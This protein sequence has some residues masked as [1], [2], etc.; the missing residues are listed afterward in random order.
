VIKRIL[1]WLSGVAIGV[2]LLL[3]LASAA[4]TGDKAFGNEQLDQMLAQIALYP[5]PLLSQV[6]MAATYPDEFAAAVAWSKAH[7]DAKGDAAVKMVESE[8]WDPSVASLVAF[9]DALITLGDKP[10]YVRNLGDAFLAQPQ[11]VMDSVQRLRQNAQKAGNLQSNEQVKVSTQ[12]APP[13]AATSTTVVVQQAAPPPQVIV[14][15]PAQPSVV[16]VPAYNPAVVYGPWWYPSYPPYYYPPPPGYWW[17]RSIATGIA[18]GVG[19]GVSN[20][21]WG[22]FD[23]GRGDVNINVNRYNNINVNKR[24][25]VNARNTTWNHDPGHRGKAPYK[26]GD[27]T[28]QKLE[29]QHEVGNREQFRGKEAARDGG[30][31]AGRDASRDASREQAA[32]AMKDRSAPSAKAAPKASATG[33]GPDRDAARQK[34]QDADRDAA[35]QRA[36]QASKDNALKGVSDRQ[37]KQQADRGA[38]SQ[39]AAQRQKPEPARAP[40][41]VGGGA[42]ASAASAKPA[43]AKPAAARPAAANPGAGNAGAAKAGGAAA[44]AGAAKADG[45]GRGRK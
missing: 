9:P 14:I 42:K 21:L 7:P 24:I 44:K 18:W 34:A 19:I 13:P 37:P 20:A 3:P 35:R 6:L 2:A 22:G 11:D 40:A 25:D 29:K 16:Y 30:R 31:D 5:D 43:A 15:E 38:A 33:P 28:R 41:P 4:Q 45:G 32:Q 26:G 23:W 12:A 8:P 17:S 36:Q 10:D 27:A 1:S 39:A